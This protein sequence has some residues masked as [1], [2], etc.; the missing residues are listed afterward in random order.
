MFHSHK[1]NQVIQFSLS[2]MVALE[3]SSVAA[4]LPPVIQ[5]SVTA[6]MVQEE[7]IVP[8]QSED[9]LLSSQSIQSSAQR[10]A[11]ET[12]VV[13]APYKNKESATA[14]QKRNAPKYDTKILNKRSIMRMATNEAEKAP[15]V[16]DGT[17][18]ARITKHVTVTAYSSTPDQT[19]ASPCTTANGFNVCKHNIE[20]VVAVN[21]VPFG[22]K[23]RF[24]DYFGDRI[25]TV[26]DRMN[27]RYTERMDVWMK[28]RQAALQFGV[29]KLK[30]EIL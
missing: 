19:D 22:T 29:R 17:T 9:I 15:A 26:Q 21:G 23:V 30:V 25:F 14:A 2:V 13:I 16:I 20:D 6:P 7:R 3:F 1:K 8:V 11:R 10:K 24:P 18:P 4:P 27:A 28:S 5:T 12:S